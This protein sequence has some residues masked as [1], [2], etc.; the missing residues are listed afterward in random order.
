MHK[1]KIEI[2]DSVGLGIIIE[3][4]TGVLIS[5]QTGG[6]ACLRPSIEGVFLPLLNEYE[7][8]S[9]KFISPEMDLSGYFI[10]ARSRGRTELGLDSEDVNRLN[11]ILRKYD[12]D[13][14]IKIDLNKLIDS[15][16]AWIHILI[17]EEDCIDALKLFAGFGP[18]PR[19]GVLTWANSD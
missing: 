12:L 11:S 6:I 18:Y 7:A 13:A 1:P 17:V 2:W 14:F 10:E 16:E 4:P 3:Y 15:H 19:E 8:D 9:E 5:N